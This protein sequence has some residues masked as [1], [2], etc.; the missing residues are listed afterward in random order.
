MTQTKKEEKSN[1]FKRNELGLFDNIEYKYLPNGYVDWR[2]MVD[3]KF[4]VP[5]STYFTGKGLP[6]PIS[7]EGLPDEQ[8]LIR[9]AGVRELARLRG[10]ERV[11]RPIS[12]QLPDG[13]AVASCKITFI[14]NFETN[15]QPLIY[16]EVASATRE[17][18]N[19]VNYA[20]TLA[21]NRSFVRAVKSAL[22]IYILSDEEFK[23]E[24][25][26]NSTD[27]Q[28]TPLACLKEVLLNEKY[29]IST[30]EGLVQYLSKTSLYKNRIEEIQSW[31]SFEG[32][33]VDELRTVLGKLK[34]FAK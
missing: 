12:Y 20:E 19:Y 16:E 30:F 31:K 11:E 24:P 4:L 32:I 10:I 18:C 33:P 9:L 34:Q 8:L 17:N 28:T 14:P 25:A 13:G 23:K 5:N 22:N 1:E 15:F 2:A 6:I 29:N 27:D 3:T 21:C 26:S 7:I